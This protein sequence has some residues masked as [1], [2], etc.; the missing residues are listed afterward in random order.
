VPETSLPLGLRVKHQIN[1]RSGLVIGPAQHGIGFGLIP[2]ALEGS[3]RRELWPIH[4]CIKKEK[5]QQ[6]KA[7]GGTFV[8]PKGFPL[9]PA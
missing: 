9:T 6:L 7:N 2:V 5:R 1:K 3:T 4:L 8:P